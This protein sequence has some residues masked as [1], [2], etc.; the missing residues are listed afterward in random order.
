MTDLDSPLTPVERLAM[1]LEGHRM[2]FSSMMARATAGEP[3]RRAA[4]LIMSRM[5]TR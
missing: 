4:W 1:H 3:E 2:E 5:T